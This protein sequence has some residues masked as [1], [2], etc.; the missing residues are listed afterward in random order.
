[1]VSVE[2]GGGQY[3]VTELFKNRNMGST[4]AQALLWDGYIYGNSADVGGGLRCL[5]LDGQI[6]WDSKRPGGKEFGMGALLIADGL[7][8]IVNGSN[9]EFVMAEATPE[10][11]RELG[12][13]PVLSGK[14]CWAP[15]AFSNGKL[16]A[17]DMQK[18]VCLDLTVGQ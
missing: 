14:E 1:M 5:T 12:R 7:I 16:V 13:A 8:Y 15:M 10:G 4:C 17:R 2:A 9:G 6:K 11:Y 18:M 3:R